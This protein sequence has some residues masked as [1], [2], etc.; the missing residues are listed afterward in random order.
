MIPGKNAGQVVQEFAR[1]RNII[2]ATPKRKPTRRLT[3]TNISIPAN[4]PV[5]TIEAE[6]QHMVASGRFCLGE[7]C[8][9]FK[10]TKYTLHDG[11]L[12]HHDI[13]VHARK[14]P[15]FEI[16]Q[17]LLAKH[18]KYMRPASTEIT[19]S[20]CMW[21]DHATIL[22]MG[23]IL[24]TVHVMYD[25]EVFLTDDEYRQ[26]HPN[27]CV[28]IQ[29]EIEQPE[30]HVLSAGSSSV[31][32]QAALVGDRLS[33]VQDLKKQVQTESEIKVRKLYPQGIN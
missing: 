17:K 19:R 32:D 6:I 2:I 9:P 20:L 27:A 16:C 28:C 12:S 31:E 23:F 1:S 8:A 15:L 10:I 30:V 11:R 24:V 33:C 13:L 22:K 26:H 21:H 3:S 18:Q 7:E 5:Q 14:I 29:A 25:S 4:P